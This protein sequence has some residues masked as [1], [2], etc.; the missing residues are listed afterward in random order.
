MK[1][2]QNV[3]TKIVFSLFFNCFSL[4]LQITATVHYLPSPL[5]KAKR[6][7][8]EKKIVTVVNQLVVR[9][10][11]IV[12]ICGLDLSLYLSKITFVSPS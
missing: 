9:P 1:I 3:E 4:Y 10:I 12:P 6:K 2:G 7:K 5:G 8:K 11:L